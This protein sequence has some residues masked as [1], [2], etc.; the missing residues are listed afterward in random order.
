MHI[1]I[2]Y[3]EEAMTLAMV[4]EHIS[5]IN[6]PIDWPVSALNQAQ[7]FWSDSQVDSLRDHWKQNGN[8]DWKTLKYGWP[9]VNS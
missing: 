5:H 2:I 4:L 1:P 8:E 6:F 9:V 3:I 7:K